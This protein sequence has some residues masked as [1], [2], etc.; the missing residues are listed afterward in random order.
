MRISLGLFCEGEYE[1]NFGHLVLSLVS[2]FIPGFEQPADPSAV[3]A[4]LV[5]HINVIKRYLKSQTY[6]KYKHL[7]ADGLLKKDT[8]LKEI[9]L[10]ESRYD[11]GTTLVKNSTF[12]NLNKKVSFTKKEC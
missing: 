12:Q 8:T 10:R 11:T 6:E 4:E 5:F 2:C 1:L 7:P 9:S 3:D